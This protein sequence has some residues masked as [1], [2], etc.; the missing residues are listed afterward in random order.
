MKK[1]IIISIICL[2]FIVTVIAFI[3]IQNNMEKEDEVTIENDEIIVDNNIEINISGEEST[4]EENLKEDEIKIRVN[5]RSLVVKLED[6]SSTEALLEKLKLGEVVLNAK[7]YGNFE[8]V[9]ELDF[10][11]PRNDEYITTEAGDLVLYQGNHIT[12]YYDNNT[13]SLTRLGKVE[14]ITQAE[15]KEILG[16]GEVI[17]TLSI[18]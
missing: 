10:T 5:G 12:L 13:W 1:K 3:V 8:K 7:D 2:V 9:A 15:L 16:D 14:N 11:L 18:N 4:M 17:L 6:N